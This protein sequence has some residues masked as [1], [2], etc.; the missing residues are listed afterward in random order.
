M[1]ILPTKPSD[2]PPGQTG[3]WDWDLLRTSLLA[4]QFIAPVTV[5]PEAPMD[6][7]G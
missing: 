6:G 2:R 1:L 5:V 4:K 7:R 3:V